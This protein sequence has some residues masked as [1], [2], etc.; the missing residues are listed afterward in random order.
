MRI[1][2]MALIP[3][4]LLLS[5]STGC[6]GGG[7][8]TITAP[9]PDFNLAVSPSAV[10][11]EVG[12]T[13]S[14]VTVTVTPQ[15]GFSGVVSVVLQGIPAGVTALP[16]ATFTVTAGARQSVTFSV[17]GGTGVGTS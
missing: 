2:C 12:G 16:A 13:T 9:T 11:S 3:L 7:A 10:S 6:G 15:N 1:R 14:A 4:C 17:S 8:S 5:L